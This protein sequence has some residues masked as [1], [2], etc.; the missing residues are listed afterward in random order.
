MDFKPNEFFLGLV[1]FIAIFLPGG[2]LAA[3]L[4]AAEAQSPMFFKEP[5]YCQSQSDGSSLAFWVCFIFSA[6][7]LGNFLSSVASGLDTYSDKIRDKIYP[8]KEG[9]VKAFLEHKGLDE[10][11][12]DREKEKE[13]EEKRKEIKN[14][15]NQDKSIEYEKF[16]KK[17]LENYCHKLLHCF[18]E[19]ERQS[20][21]KLNAA[22]PKVAN[23]KLNAELGGA[24][25]HYQWSSIIL[26]TLY[27]AAAERVNKF[28]AA[29]KFF[30]SLVVVFALA[31]VCELFRCLIVTFRLDVIFGFIHLPKSVQIAHWSWCLA[32]LGLATLS[33]REYVVQRQKSI[34]A[35]YRAILTLAH[36]P[37]NFKKE[38]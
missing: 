27:P 24:V 17:F 35:A 29:S 30:R 19:F 33:F 7:T 5:F 34:Q 16:E 18:F 8:H 36:L 20:P 9:I 1:D 37:D 28:M 31:F 12:L 25:N 15:I 2:L 22:L 26:D 13:Q 11:G 38:K 4:L 32:W 21:L 3:L 10:K 23:I 6:Y 14:H